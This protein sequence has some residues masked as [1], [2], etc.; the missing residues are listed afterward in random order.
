MLKN[1]G[2]DTN[3]LIKVRSGAVICKGSDPDPYLKKESQIRSGT[4][5]PDSKE[6][7]GYQ[8]LNN[9]DFYIE[10]E[11]LRLNFIRPNPDPGFFLSGSTPA[12][13]A[14][15]LQSMGNNCTPT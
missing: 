6:E 7:I 12:G 5:H 9:I 2:A 3:P 1:R 11:K 8:Y 14:T 13:P 4:E 15:L 10:S